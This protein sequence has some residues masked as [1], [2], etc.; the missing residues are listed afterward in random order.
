[1]AKQSDGNLRHPVAS[2]DL[3]EQRPEQHEQEHE[4]RRNTE[5]HAVDAFGNEPLV[6]EE[7]AE[8]GAL[9]LEHLGH[10]RPDESVCDEHG[11]HDDHGEAKRAAR[12]L[13]QEEY[14]RSCR[15]EID[16]DRLAGPEGQLA[17]EQEEI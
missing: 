12:G 17:I 14:S 4:A 5:C 6:I 15:D 9:V 13:Q 1:M 10:V 16:H 11:R 2:A 8:R 3:V 7:F